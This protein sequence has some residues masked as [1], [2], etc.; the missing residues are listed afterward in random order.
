VSW[1]IVS[2]PMVFAAGGRALLMQVA[3]P[4]VAAAVAEH[5]SFE[6]DPW[7]RLSGTMRVMLKMVFGSPAQS[8]RESRHLAQLHSNVSGRTPAGKPYKASDPQLLTWVW[9]TLVDTSLAAFERSRG[10][11]EDR[12]RERFY[13]EQKL[14][15]RA[16]G[17]P[18]SL[19]PRS[20]VNFEEYLEAMIAG[21]L[22]VTSEA[23]VIAAS[24]LEP[25]LRRP[26]GSLATGPFQLLTVGLLP[27]PL[28]HGYGF[29][30]SGAHEELLG[31]WLLGT[32]FVN[33][34]V[35]PF[36][37]QAAFSAVLPL[38]RT[39]GSQGGDRRPVTLAPV[40]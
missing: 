26:F 34:F 31:L 12:A 5:S 25:P 30:W 24:V 18:S 20:I 39:G 2:E 35:P 14:V 33:S 7:R 29:E 13:L 23:K 9:A 21:E 40:A 28:R 32:R 22:H 3:H 4:A 15:A 1:R 16:C 37:R 8:R 36:L 27:D 6:E 38:L 17:V 19:C 10:R 11:L